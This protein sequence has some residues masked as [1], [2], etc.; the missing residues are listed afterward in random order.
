M[1]TATGYTV[2][3]T[4]DAPT[5]PCPCGASTRVLTAADAGPCSLHVT[6]IHDSVRHY[7]RETTLDRCNT[8]PDLAGNRTLSPAT[9]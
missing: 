9:G 3:R 6:G 5:V 2:R 8:S 4:A 1:P 7:H